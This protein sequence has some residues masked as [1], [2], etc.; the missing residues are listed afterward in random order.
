MRKKL[1]ITLNLS[2]MVKDLAGAFAEANGRSLSVLIEDLLRKELE[3]HGIST[4]ISGEEL[5]RMVQERLKAKR[6]K[7]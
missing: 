7:K 1:P 3:S 4:T 5:H 2:P 6:K